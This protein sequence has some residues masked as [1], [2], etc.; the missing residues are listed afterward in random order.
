M[1]DMR[2]LRYGQFLVQAHGDVRQNGQTDTHHSQE[3]S[4]HARSSPGAEQRRQNYLKMLHSVQ[5]Q[6]VYKLK[7]NFI[8]IWD[9]FPVLCY[10]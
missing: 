8:I 6:L 10:S 9:F 2:V 4:E 7:V 5:Y 3:H 1:V